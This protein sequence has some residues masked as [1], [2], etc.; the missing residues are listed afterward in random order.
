M[1]LWV[2]ES[3]LKRFKLF[4]ALNGIHLS[5]LSFETSK[6]LHEDNSVRC[7]SLK[8]PDKTLTH[9]GKKTASASSGRPLN[10]FCGEQVN[11]TD[12]PTCRRSQTAAD[13]HR[14]EAGGWGEALFSGAWMGAGFGR[15]GRRSMRVS[16]SFWDDT[17]HGNSSCRRSLGAGVAMRRAGISHGHRERRRELQ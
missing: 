2:L 3:V 1:A 6:R 11:W 13:M 5:N 8:P 12:V 15:G 14:E 9:G 17:I 10:H 16:L 7:D 4:Q